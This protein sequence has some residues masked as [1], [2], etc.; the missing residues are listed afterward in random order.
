MLQNGLGLVRVG[1]NPAPVTKLRT[2]VGEQIDIT[3]FVRFP[4]PMAGT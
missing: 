3:V 4:S 1:D 2:F